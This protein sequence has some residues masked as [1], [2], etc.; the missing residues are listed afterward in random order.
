MV[1]GKKI[2]YSHMVCLNNNVYDYIG[3]QTNN[4]VW[5]KISDTTWGQVRDITEIIV[6]NQ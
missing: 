3:K 6:W 5:N 1:L 4:Y 2:S